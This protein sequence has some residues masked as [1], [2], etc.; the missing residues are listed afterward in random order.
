MSKSPKAVAPLGNGEIVSYALANSGQAMIYS[1]IT[2]Y[3]LLFMTDYL[4]INAAVAGLILSITRVFDALNDPLMGAILDKTHTRWGK[5][6]PYMLFTPIPVAILTLLLFAPINLSPTSSIVYV[7]VIYLLFTL[8]YTANDIPYWSM[9]AVITNEAEKRVKVVTATKIIGGIGSGLAMSAFWFTNKIFADFGQD[10]RYSFFFT[11]TIFCV[12]GTVLMLQGFFGTRERARSTVK[13]GEKFFDNLKLIPKSRALL[14]NLLSGILMSVMLVGSTALTSYFVKWNFKEIFPTMESNTMMSIF[15]PALIILP[16]IAMFA[17]QIC[18][19]LLIKKFEKRDLLLA[20]CVMGIVFNTASYFWGY[21]N[22]LLFILGRVL[23]FL[24]LGAWYAITTI[25]IGDSVDEIEYKTGRRVEGACFSLLTFVSKFQNGACVAITGFL[26][27]MAGYAGELDPDFAQQTSV[28][29][30]MI[31]ILVT[32]VP[33]I[34]FLI[35]GI[36]F[37]FYNLSKSKHTLILT[38]LQKRQSKEDKEDSLAF[39]LD[40]YK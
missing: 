18:T 17:G 1:I 20:G 24:P 21:T 6:R 22:L 37:L 36:P 7:S 38:E 40:W 30:K 9:S 15:V 13:E 34:G 10:K 11:V 5:C 33:A 19:P 26:L 16:G 23:G 25:M 29:L 3:L 2:T 27:S 39:D 8:A 32:L 35:M 12:F 4:Y 28:V 14:I 31:F